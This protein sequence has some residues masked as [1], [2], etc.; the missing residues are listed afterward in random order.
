[1]SPDHTPH[2]ATPDRVVD[3]T[4]RPCPIPVIELAKA[5]AGAELGAVVKLLSDDP[6]SGVDVPVWCRMKGQRLLTREREAGVWTFLVE[7]VR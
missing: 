5:V 7:R 6:A 1:M 2:S 4:G 3:A